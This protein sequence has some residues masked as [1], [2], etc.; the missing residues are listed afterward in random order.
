MAAGSRKERSG[1]DSAL[2]PIIGQM[3]WAAGLTHDDM[4]RT[5]L[6]KLD[7]MLG[8]TSTSIED[9][10]LFA[11]MLSLANGGHYP[12]LELLPE[13][14][15]QKTLDALMAQLQALTRTNPVLMILEDAH[16]SDP[17]TLELFG[18]VVDR[19]RSLRALLIVTFRPEFESPWIGMAHVTALTINRLAQRDID[20]MIDRVVGNQSLPANIRKD[21]I[22]RTDGIP[23]FVEEMT[24]AVLEVGNDSEAEH[25]AAAV[26]HPGL[27]VPGSL[28]ASLMARLDRLGPAKEVAQIG[29]AIGREFSH[30]LLA[31]VASKPEAEL[32]SALDRLVAAG[33]LFRQGV[34]PQA[35]YLFKHAL[36]QDAAYGT[37]LRQPRRA[38]HA[39]VAETLE[40]ELA[41]I[42][43][44]QPEILAHHCTE[45][46]LIE[47]AAGLWGRAGHRSM[48]RSA[49]VEAAA[50]LA[51]ALEQ[52]A[53][54]P[55]TPAL[56]REQI[57][58]Q[59]A[60]ITPLFH[61]KGYAATEPKAAAEQAR[62]LIEQTEALGEPPED[63]LLLFQVLFGLWVANQVA[64]NGDVCRELAMQLLALAEKQK[65]TVPLMIGHGTMGGA[66][67][68][69]GDIVESRA[70]YDQVIALYEPAAHRPL[71]TRF[72]QDRRVTALSFQSLGLWL[73]GYPEAARRDADDAVE[74][75]REV[76]QAGTLM[77]A[78][79][80]TAIP[81]TLCGNWPWEPRTRKSLS[82]WP[83]KRA[84]CFGR[85]SE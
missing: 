37:L 68:L 85:H 52:I 74:N 30:A 47:N 36:V 13:Q 57:K 75:A 15:R 28:H 45:A 40:S 38:L 26:P 62:L 18:R 16:W 70:H 61:I 64:F 33:L 81:H 72:G 5:K 53:T 35:T 55:G 56:R 29:A 1:T 82:L 21:I 34:P 4:P 24:K 44:S 10:A 31:A 67:V 50:Q 14:R 77:L 60:L 41:E 2:Y 43:G 71:A 65:A 17:T 27:A 23:L 73:L 20:A 12:A 54:L 84:P 69:A 66:L 49:L 42:A 59:V 25:V 48:E 22:E 7:A 8:Q 19:I 9:M 46:G 51:R 32:E 83:K 58:L 6:D 3:E 79:C 80:H 39:R 78:L 63:P 76:G 11:E